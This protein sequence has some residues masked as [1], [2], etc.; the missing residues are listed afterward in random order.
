[1][2][3]LLYIGYKFNFKKLAVKIFKCDNLL[4][5]EASSISL[6]FQYHLF[7]DE[8]KSLLISSIRVFYRK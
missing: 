3:T 6:R 1:M 8:A 7:I 5:T 2:L 4:N